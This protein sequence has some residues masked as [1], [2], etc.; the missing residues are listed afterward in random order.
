[1]SGAREQE[2]RVAAFFD[3]DGT[4]V[5]EPS[6][7]RRLFRE[8]RRT[9]AMPWMNYARWGMEAARLL[10]WGLTA[11]A[12]GNKSYL[13]GLREEQILEVVEPIAV[14]EEG[15]ARGEWHGGRG[16]EIGLGRGMG[17]PLARMVGM[18]LGC[19]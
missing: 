6:L 2:R 17:E 4:L 15:V 18:S 11:I 10:P 19:E 13:R 8:L 12:H 9:H 7:E 16:N 3:I 5:P 1:M 14:F